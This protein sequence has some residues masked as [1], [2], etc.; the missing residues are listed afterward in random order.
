M[1]QARKAILGFQRAADILSSLGAASVDRT[2]LI[3][4]HKDAKQP[5]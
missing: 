5:T 4:R 1:S 3:L 2:R